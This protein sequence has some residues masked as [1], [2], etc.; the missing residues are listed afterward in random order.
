MLLYVNVYRYSIVKET[1]GN[2]YLL[3]SKQQI[4]ENLLWKECA[5]SLL[6]LLTLMTTHHCSTAR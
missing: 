5:H 1:M 3:L 2:L 4:K 6:R